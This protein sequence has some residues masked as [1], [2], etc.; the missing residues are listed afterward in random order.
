MSVIQY[1]IYHDES[2][3]AGY[4]HG[5]LLIPRESKLFIKEQLDHFRKN[6]GLYEF[7][8]FKGMG[9]KGRKYILI[10]A[11]LSF[12]QCCLAQ[13]QKKGSLYYFTGRKIGKGK[14]R[15][16]E[17]LKLN[18]LIKAKFILFRIPDDHESF[19]KEFHNDYA[20]LVETSFRIGLKGGLKSL[21]EPTSE[22]NIASFHFDNHEHYGRSLDI[23]KII[24]RLSDLPPNIKFADDIV[25]DDRTSNHCKTNCQDYIDCQLLQATDLVIGAF[26]TVLGE[27]KNKTQIEASKPM[28]DLSQKWFAGKSRMNNSR[29]RNGFCLSQGFIENGQWSFPVF[30]KRVK[31][32]NYYQGNLF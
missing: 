12:I 22:I 9:A 19:N 32:A 28:E 30:E 10:R 25:V 11:W 15:R 3:E 6:V 17:I 20:S 26:R 13:R 14:E 2:K 16:V 4:W 23:N 5:I 1:D 21:I 27:A 31:I 18:G 24:N 8:T 29:W 7:L